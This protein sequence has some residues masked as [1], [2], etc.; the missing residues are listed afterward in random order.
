MTHL[1]ATVLSE[2]GFTILND[3]YFDTLTMKSDIPRPSL[4][5]GAAKAMVYFS[6][7]EDDIITLSL[8]ETM[9]IEKLEDIASLLCGKNIRLVFLLSCFP[10]ESLTLL[11]N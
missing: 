4:A 2:N 10:N 5:S 11:R 6:D 3:T 7:T 8:N 9:T 1:L